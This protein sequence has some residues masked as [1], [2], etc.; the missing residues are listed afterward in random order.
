MYFSSA[1]V[2]VPDAPPDALLLH[3]AH[4]A[5]VAIPSGCRS[6]SC[7][8][9]EVEL[10]VRFRADAAPTPGD[11]LG[12]SGDAGFAVVR[13]CVTRLPRAAAALTVVELRDDDVW[14]S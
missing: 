6:G 1:D 4:E 14:G 13:A 8:A 2:L 3:V 11:E 7:G 5:G 10:C 9:C 12:T